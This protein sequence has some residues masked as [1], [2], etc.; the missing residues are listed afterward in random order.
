MAYDRSGIADPPRLD[1]PCT[2]PDG[3][4][5]IV[6]ADRS[7]GQEQPVCMHCGAVGA[8]LQRGQSNAPR[9]LSK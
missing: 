6:I 1:R 5:H 2:G 7:D 3:H 4:H 9:V 8:V